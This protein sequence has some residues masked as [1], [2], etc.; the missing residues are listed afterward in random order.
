MGAV[1]RDNLHDKYWKPLLRSS[2][3]SSVVSSKKRPPSSLHEHHLLVL[4]ALRGDFPL[5]LPCPGS[6]CP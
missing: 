1:R 3:K 5:T 6:A 2:P 4:V